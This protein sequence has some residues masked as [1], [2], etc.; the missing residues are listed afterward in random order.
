MDVEKII[1]FIQGKGLKFKWFE[2]LDVIDYGSIVV[3]DKE[4]E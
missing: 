2:G 1:N 4:G 3:I